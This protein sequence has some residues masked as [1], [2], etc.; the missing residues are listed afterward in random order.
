MQKILCAAIRY[1]NDKTY[2]SGPLN[3]PTGLVVCGRRHHDCYTV[4]EQVVDFDAN[5]LEHEDFGFMTDENLYLNR[6]E[7]YPIALAAG[8]VQKPE[9]HDESNLI[10]I[11]EDLYWGCDK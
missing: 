9:L 3:V 10:L 5:A 6:K 4:L 2:S 8:Q 1:R 11:S 7:A